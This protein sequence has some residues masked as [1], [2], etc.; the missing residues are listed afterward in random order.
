[1]KKELLI[2][3]LSL[4]TLQ[5]TAQ[6]LVSGTDEI[7]IS[8]LEAQGI[9]LPGEF[10]YKSYEYVSPTTQTPYTL[11]AA[12]AHGNKIIFNNG[13]S[14]HNTESKGYLKEVSLKDATGYIS[15]YA[16]ENPIDPSNLM[17]EGVSVFSLNA[18]NDYKVSLDGVFRYFGIW[19]VNASATGIQAEWRDKATLPVPV[20]VLNSAV[21]CPS[22]S[23]VTISSNI[24]DAKV[25]VKVSNGEEILMEKTMENPAQIT[26]TGN[27]DDKITVEARTISDAPQWNP[28]EWVKRTYTITDIIMVEPELSVSPYDNKILRGETVT[29]TNPNALGEIIYSVCGGEEI[30]SAEKTV[31][32]TVDAEPDTQWSVK[33]RC[34]YEGR[35]SETVEWSGKVQS[36]ICPK[37]YFNPAPGEYPAGRA[38]TFSANSPAKSITY[39][40]NGGEWINFTNLKKRV[41][42]T[43][44]DDMTIEVYSSADAPYVDSETVTAVYTVEQL[45]VDC[46]VVDYKTFGLEATSE[47]G[48]Y[49]SETTAN[50]AK[51]SLN[52]RSMNEGL[53]VGGSGYLSVL[54]NNK[55]INRIK[56]DAKFSNQ[57]IIYLSSEKIE[58]RDDSLLSYTVIN[59]DYESNQWIP[60]PSD[61]N[62]K[63]FY[64]TT[65]DPKLSNTLNRVVV[66]YTPNPTEM[67]NLTT[68]GEYDELA[69]IVIDF[70]NATDVLQSGDAKPIL[71]DAEGKELDNVITISPAKVKEGFTGMRMIL[72][73][74]PV[75]V[76][77]GAYT[78]ELPAG[79][80]ICDGM[81]S[82]TAS[83]VYEISGIKTGVDEINAETTNRDIYHINGTL[84]RRNAGAEII[85]SL[86]KGIYI[87]NGRK[88]IVK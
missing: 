22:G 88:V 51:Y 1:M 43:L 82:V 67:S 87:I 17:A 36:N 39:R 40:I 23:T 7:S 46:D 57:Y 65:V 69:E 76:E 14:L 48:V 74:D 13:L 75:I 83:Y 77:K 19:P 37:P 20:V 58:G 60:M 79:T 2:C 54:D 80:F 28:S 25:E 49:E 33:A 34:E 71:K 50:G 70:P 45:P 44:E 84:I 73:I 12:Y 9:Y 47:T 30:T 3:A 66:D 16:S 24:A 26:L 85:N 11:T 61:S 62:I 86:D 59:G 10:E 56:V 4:F 38:I 6:D 72:S 81:N 63:Y 55:R 68:P 53:S 21:G 18:S 52:G 42:V 32:L 5:A 64:L 8:T 35:V 78:L 15:L 27:I 41:S 31:V 29:L